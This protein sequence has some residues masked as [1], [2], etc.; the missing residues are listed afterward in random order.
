MPWSEELS[1]TADPRVLLVSQRRARHGLAQALQFELEDRVREL[2]A[3]D[4]VAPIRDRFPSRLERRAGAVADRVSP[5]LGDVVAGGRPRVAR[6][7]ELAVVVVGGLADLQYVW[8]QS[9][10]FRAAR[11]TACVVDDVWR[12][13]LAARAGELRMLS[14]FDQVFVGT[15]GTVEEMARLTGRPCSY[16]SPSVDALALCPFPEPRAR[17]IDVYSM[18]RRSRP[19]HEALR[20]LAVERRWFYLYDTLSGCTATDYAEHRRHLAGLL[21]RTRFLLAYPGKRDARA[22]TGGQEEIGYRYF[23]GAAA[24][25]VLVGE[26]PRNPWFRELFGWEDAIVHLPYDC[27]DP[28]A[29]G[30]AFGLDPQREA[31]ISLA[32]VA[33]ALRRHDHVHRWAEVLRC[34][35]MAETPAMAARRRI[36]EERADTIAQTAPPLAR[37]GRA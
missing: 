2:D 14:R 34:A 35:G 8:P 6:R 23:E 22:E 29:L 25:A 30:A 32:N 13:G 21:T 5:A 24:G 7:Y 28:A 3:V 27:T 10:L 15:A 37:A 16:L 4:L 12:E 17:V 33:G 18:G 20:A 11:T 36:L 9:W 31:R 19:T 26:A 1:A